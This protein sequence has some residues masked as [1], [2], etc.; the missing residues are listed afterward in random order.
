[1]AD[2]KDVVEF[3]IG[4]GL[5][6]MDINLVREIVE[7]LPI[8]RLPGSQNCI[9]GVI[10]LRGEVTTI[11]S[12]SDLLNIKDQSGKK[13]EKIIVMVS[14]H[15]GGSNIGIIVRDVHSVLSVPVEDIEPFSGILATDSGGFVKG[16]IK[17][18]SGDRGRVEETGKNSRLMLYLDIG[19]ILTELHL[20]CN[21]K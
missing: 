10:N 5:Y 15:T 12:I 4:S 14:D 20:P 21:I 19:K 17:T 18:T 6:G 1:M 8:T 9:V 16:I 11:I 13:D 3:E 7:M 2:T